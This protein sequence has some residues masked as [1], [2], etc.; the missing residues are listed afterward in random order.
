MTKTGD[1]LKKLS[2]AH[3]AAGFLKLIPQFL[4]DAVAD[5]QAESSGNAGEMARQ[6]DAL[7]DDLEAMIENIGKQ[8]HSHHPD[9]HDQSQSGSPT[10]QHN[11]PAPPPQTQGQAASSKP[12]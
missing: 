9:T 7:A 12:K 1:D 6:L 11:A 4:K 3:D 10:T 2:E 8:P 5:A